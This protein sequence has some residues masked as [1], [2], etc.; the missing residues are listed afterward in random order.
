MWRNLR[1][2]SVT[3]AQIDDATQDV[4]L[5]VHRKL[6]DFAGRS[7]L[8]TWIFGVLFRVAADYQRS[9]R[10]KRGDAR[11]RAG[12]VDVDALA[13]E[14]SNVKQWTS[15][16][17]SWT[18]ARRRLSPHHTSR[19]GAKSKICS[20]HPGRLQVAHQP[21]RTG[22]STLEQVGVVASGRDGARERR[23]HHVPGHTHGWLDGVVSVHMLSREL[24]GRT[25]AGA[26]ATAGAD[27]AAVDT[28]VELADGDTTPKTFDVLLLGDKNEEVLEA[29]TLN[30]SDP[31]GGATLGE[32][33]VLT[34]SVNDSAPS[35]CSSLGVHDA[36]L[37]VLPF[38]RGCWRVASVSR[39]GRPRRWCSACRDTP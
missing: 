29:F 37:F 34:V 17:A 33:S 14:R 21:R 1:R 23:R 5:V 36:W 18:T 15:C 16:I 39:A 8:K 26:V 30:L 9:L 28:V 31:T 2:L 24:P 13:D 7:S 4:F 6:A 25:D 32:P 12:E 10:R 35:G 22:P 19:A 27:F 3:D 20:Q 38:A 11:S